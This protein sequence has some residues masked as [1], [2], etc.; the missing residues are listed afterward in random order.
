MMYYYQEYFYSLL[1]LH[2]AGKFQPK[3]VM[4]RNG[5]LCGYIIFS[6][7]IKYIVDITKIKA[8]SKSHYCIA[9]N[10]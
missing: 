8:K 9:R 3:N 2:S 1:E 7:N 5:A 6:S 4:K 10:L